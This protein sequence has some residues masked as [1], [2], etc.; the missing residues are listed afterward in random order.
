MV[1]VSHICTHYWGPAFKI[2]H[3]H[4]VILNIIQID[5]VSIGPP[6]PPREYASGE[7]GKQR[8]KRRKNV[9]AQKESEGWHLS[10]HAKVTTSLW[11]IKDLGMVVSNVDGALKWTHTSYAMLLSG[12]PWGIPRVTCISWYTHL[13]VKACVYTKKYK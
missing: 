7:S 6:L 2:C 8:R 9:K 1:L 4:K 10:I 11:K 3:N 5:L 12:I 13:W